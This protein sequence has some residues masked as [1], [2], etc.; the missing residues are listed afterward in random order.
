MKWAVVLCAILGIDS[1]RPVARIC[2]LEDLSSFLPG[3]HACSRLRR[4]LFSHRT[5]NQYLALLVAW[6]ALSRKDRAI[7]YP[8]VSRVK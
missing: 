8:M 4:R 5:F 7:F 6:D 3:A 1:G 2:G